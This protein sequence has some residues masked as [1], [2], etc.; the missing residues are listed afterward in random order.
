MRSVDDQTDVE[1]GSDRRLDLRPDRADAWVLTRLEFQQAEDQRRTKGKDKAQGTGYGPS[2][3]S[4][5]VADLS[6][7]NAVCYKVRPLY[8]FPLSLSCKLD[9]ETF[10]LMTQR[11]ARMT[12]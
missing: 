4:L 10:G 12:C 11:I 8:M 6:W 9:A 5:I 1:V 2:S 7:G 3:L